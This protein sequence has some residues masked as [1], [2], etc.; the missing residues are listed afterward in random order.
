MMALRKVTVYLGLIGLLCASNAIAGKSTSTPNPANN[1]LVRLLL[2]STPASFKAPSNRRGQEPST[3]IAYLKPKTTTA[4]TTRQIGETQ[5]RAIVTSTGS[6][7]QA[8]STTKIAYQRP[9]TTPATRTRQIGETQTRAILTSTASTT[10]TAEVP[11][12]PGIADGPTCDSGCLNIR[13]ILD[14]SAFVFPILKLML[15]KNSKPLPDGFFIRGSRYVSLSSKPASF[16]QALQ[17]CTI[18]DADLFE[19]RTTQDF[20]FLREL[21]KDSSKKRLWLNLDYVSPRKAS[22][23]LVYPTGHYPLR[24][25]P[26]VQRTL[27]PPIDQEQCLA[28]DV[29][30]TPR[31]VAR[32]C[33][34]KN[35]YVC[36]MSFTT[37]RAVSLLVSSFKN[38]IVNFA[39]AT[40]ANL[41]DMDLQS[42]LCPLFGD[43][44]TKLKYPFT[45]P[46]QVNRLRS[47]NTNVYTLPE[48]FLDIT[49]VDLILALVALF[50]I[51]LTG[52]RMCNRPQCVCKRESLQRPKTP[53]PTASPSRKRA[54][55]MPTP[56]QKVSH[57]GQSKKDAQTGIKLK[58][59]LKFT[60]DAMDVQASQDDSSSTFSSE[61]PPTLPTPPI[62]RAPTAP[63]NR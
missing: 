60:D 57:T 40:L 10:S 39:K 54:R 62:L 11:D 20:E 42:C 26:G 56:Q 38:V 49:L 63:V 17:F 41:Q 23:E 4:A 7:T 14:R 33:S 48:R 9:T 37:E 18:H 15:E 31:Y 53:S 45:N 55:K 19:L 21:L 29:L 8:A 43:R 24:L 47:K 25:L 13:D 34:E 16:D 32:P 22:G 5:T 27:I 52:Y 30:I 6:T 59:I 46:P 2:G 3:K 36:T 1:P 12:S 51:V 44:N 28:I 50:T 58:K 35:M 61:P